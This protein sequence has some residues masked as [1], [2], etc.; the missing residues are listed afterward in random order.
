MNPIWQ[1]WWVMEALENANVDYD[2]IATID[3]DTMV[4]WDTPNFFD[5]TNNKFSCMI[6]NDN[7]NWLHQSINIYQK[8]SFFIKIMIFIFLY[9]RIYVVFFFLNIKLFT[10]IQLLLN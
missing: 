2:Q 8:F 1:K 7:V 5:M 9:T 4:R 10:N 3:A 6:D